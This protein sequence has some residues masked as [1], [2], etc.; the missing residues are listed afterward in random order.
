ML[1]E[2]PL[3][4]ACICCH[5]LLE[6]AVKIELNIG[7]MVYY[8][9]HRAFGVLIKCLK[10]D[11]MKIWSYSLRSPL[12]NNR[13]TIQVSILSTDEDKFIDAIRTGTLKHYAKN[14]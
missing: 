13:E 9:P 12:C 10:E 4:V 2:L 6:I 14:R 5:T 1:L 7:D 8:A 3:L 11:G